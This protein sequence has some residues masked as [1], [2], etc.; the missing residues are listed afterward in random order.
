[1]TPFVCQYYFE[2]GS[3]SQNSLVASNIT[4]WLRSET[5]VWIGNEQART[6][7]QQARTNKRESQ[8][9]IDQEVGAGGKER[10]LKGTTAGSVERV[11]C[12]IHIPGKV[13][14]AEIQIQDLA[15][16]SRSSNGAP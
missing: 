4:R 16:I 12:A 10:G 9:E 6:F 15:E 11:A 13:V 5:R 2:D 14:P 1:L 8:V 3:R 7:L